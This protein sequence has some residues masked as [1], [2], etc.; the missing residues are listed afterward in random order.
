M[1]FL[2]RAPETIVAGDWPHKYGTRHGLVEGVG[3]AGA[4][5]WRQKDC[6]PYKG[7]DSLEAKKMSRWVRA[8][9]VPARQIH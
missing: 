2:S 7:R 9:R 5:P 1:F 6:L 4:A 3:G 8:S